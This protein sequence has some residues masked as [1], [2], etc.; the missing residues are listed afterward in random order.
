MAFILDVYLIIKAFLLEE[1][2]AQE[3]QRCG[4]NN[5]PCNTGLIKSLRL[6]KRKVAQHFKQVKGLIISILSTCL[7]GLVLPVLNATVKGTGDDPTIGDFLVKD[8]F[9]SNIIYIHFIINSLVYSLYYK[10]IRQSL[11]KMITRSC[12]SEQYRV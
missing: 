9:M 2:Y 11:F 10:Q 12:R 7:L 1:K 4:T 3:I 5:E 6:A 8:L